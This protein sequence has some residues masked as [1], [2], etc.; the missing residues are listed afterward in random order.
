ME[1]NKPKIYTANVVSL[2]K[3]NKKV[4]KIDL[5]NIS[6]TKFIYLPG[7]YISVQVD[8]KTYRSY[9]LYSD[10]I[11]NQ[12]FSIIAAIEH[13]G[14]GSNFLRGLTQGQTVNFIGPSGRFVL[15]S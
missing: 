15:P 9:S 1:F 12:S 6:T 7:Q 11:T 8:Q 3:L 13:E 5:K 14:V 10:D 4:V 2:K